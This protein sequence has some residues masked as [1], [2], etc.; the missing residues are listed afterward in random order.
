MEEAPDRAGACGL[1]RRV[2]DRDGAH[3]AR[4]A[5]QER[6]GERADDHRLAHLAAPG[7]EVPPFDV[8]RVQAVVGGAAIGFDA[9]QE[10]EPVAL[11]RGV[12]VDA[13]DRLHEPPA[14]PRLHVQLAVERLHRRQSGRHR[15]HGEHARSAVARDP[16]RR[17]PRARALV[18]AAGQQD[19]RKGGEERTFH[20]SAFERTAFGSVARTRPRCLPT[21][22]RP[23]FVFTLRPST[24]NR[25]PAAGVETPWSFCETTV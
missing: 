24:S 19:E 23:A 17:A 13:L 10:P 20:L 14:V 8:A 16:E 25:A 9:V 22:P 4:V 7:S 11:L 1:A 18:P 2:P 6:L 3:V 15:A 5:V 21:Q 12:A